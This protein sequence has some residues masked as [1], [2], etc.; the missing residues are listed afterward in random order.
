[1]Q[2]DSDAARKIMES[3]TLFGDLKK[4]AEKEVKETTKQSDLTMEM[5]K[6]LANI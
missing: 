2:L 3:E 1:M 6:Q 5:P 4:L